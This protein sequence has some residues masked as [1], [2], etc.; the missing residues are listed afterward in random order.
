MTDE[1]PKDTKEKEPKNAPGRPPTHG[2]YSA[3]KR[4]KARNLDRRRADDQALIAFQEGVIA[5]LGGLD[6]IDM[7]QSSLIDRAVECVIILR[8]MGAYAEE[9]GVMAEDGNLVP[10]LRSSYIAYLNSFRLT[11]ESIYSRA[12]K[13]KKAK[14]PSIKDIIEGKAE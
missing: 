13:S 2:G 5:D 11:M 8:S 10:C 6:E 1:N 3:L 9:R 7:L 4:Y 12:G 14:I